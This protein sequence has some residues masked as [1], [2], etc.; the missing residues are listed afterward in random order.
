MDNLVLWNIFGKKMIDFLK[1]IKSVAITTWFL[2]FINIF[3]GKKS[4]KNLKT[5]K[6]NKNSD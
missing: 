6:K 3:L 1:F 5:N 4:E 2:K